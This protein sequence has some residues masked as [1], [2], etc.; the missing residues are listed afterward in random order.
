MFLDYGSII[1]VFSGYVGIYSIIRQSMYVWLFYLVFILQLIKSCQ[2]YYSIL[3]TKLNREPQIT[4]IAM[5]WANNVLSSVWIILDLFGS[6]TKYVVTFKKAFCYKLVT[7]S[8]G[9]F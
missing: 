4:Y 3:I 1:S 7:K 8:L 9:V 2:V 6:V 5:Q